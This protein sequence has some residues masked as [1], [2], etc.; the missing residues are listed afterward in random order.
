MN[1]LYKFCV[2]GM[3]GHEKI[4]TICNQLLTILVGLLV[5]RDVGVVVGLDVGDD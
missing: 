4:I 5:G 1:M 2:R 3:Y